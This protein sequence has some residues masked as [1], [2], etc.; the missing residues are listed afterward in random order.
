[1][2]VD[3]VQ[4]RVGG[5]MP[6]AGPGSSAGEDGPEAVLGG[7]GA[8]GGVKGANGSGGGG[9]NSSSGG[10]GKGSSGGGKKGSTG[11]GGAKVEIRKRQTAWSALAPRTRYHPT[12]REGCSALDVIS[13]GIL[14]VHKCPRK[15][16]S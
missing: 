7:S 10:G 8:G 15:S 14:H 2:A 11:G 3:Q 4:Q 9:K 6:G 1:M 13:G 12:R 5:V 16:S